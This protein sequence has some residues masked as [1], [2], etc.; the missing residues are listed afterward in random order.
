MRRMSELSAIFF[1]IDDTLYSTTEFAVQA[2]R[3]SVNAMI[4]AGLRMDPEECLRELNEVIGEF[5]SNYEQHFDKLLLR[6]P[7]KCYDGINP[8]ILIASAVVAYHDTKVQQLVPFPNVPEVLE[9]L[10]QTNLILGVITDG[11][12]IKQAEKLV[13]LR[14]WNTSPRPSSS[15]IRSASASRTPSSTR[16]PAR[17]W[18][19]TRTK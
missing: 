6:I 8:G 1:D 9:R 11:R 17:T 4:R 14:V 15:R 12:D 18:G 13:R 3:N 10:S 16:R 2:R 7:Q 5:S 19:L